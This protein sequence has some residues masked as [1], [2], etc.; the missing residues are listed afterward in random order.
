MYRKIVIGISTS[1][2]GV[3]IK[4]FPTDIVLFIVPLKK[5]LSGP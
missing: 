5:L 1:T 4:N 3:K 2:T